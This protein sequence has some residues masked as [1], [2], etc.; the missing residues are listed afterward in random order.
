MAKDIDLSAF[1]EDIDLSAFDEEEGPS[2]LE[3][4]GRGAVQ[5][6][7]LGFGE[8]I[9]AAA[10]SPVEML[11]QKIAKL[12]PGSMENVDEQLRQQGFKGL[13]EEELTDI[14]KNLRDT[15]RERNKAAEEAHKATYIASDVAGGILPGL[16]SGGG[17]AAA[18][19]L[20]TGTKEAMKQAAK[21]GA[22]Y[23]AV[24]GLGYG[25]GETI[26]ED[27]QSTLVGGVLGAGLGA[28][29]PLAVKGAKIGA[30]KLKK[31]AQD[32]LET[33][34]P[35]S[36]A[37]KAGYKYGRQGK[38]LTQEVIDEDLI[39]I[40]KKIL[41]NIQSDKSAN[42]LKAAKE[43]L[44]ALG[45]VVNT[46]KTIN[47]AIDD[48]QKLTNEDYLGIQNKE[49]LPKI[50]E[51]TGYST[52]AERMAEKAQ[53]Q[54][55]KKVIESQGKIDQA[56]IKG[57]KDLAKAQAKTGD[58]LETITDVKRPMSDLDIPLQTKEG[59]VAGT[60]GRFKGPEGEDYIK[61][62][63]SDA[64][65]YQPEMTSM[66]DDLGRPIIKT[67]DKGS[68]RVS[69]MVG[70]IEDKIK[71]NLE[72]M[73]VSEVESLRKQLNLATKLAKA[74]GAAD[75]PIMQRA[76]KLAGELK[77][78][79]DEVVE[80]SGDTD[81]IRNRARFSDIFSAEEMLGIDKRFSVRRDIQEEL[82]ATQLGGKLGFEQGFKTRQEGEL[83][84]KLLG[85]KVVT[86]EMRQQL[87]LIRKLNQVSGRE[88]QE[89]ISRAGL[90][91]MVVG[92]IPNI[93]GRGVKA[94]GDI[95]RPITSPVKNTMDLLNT[96]T[97]QQVETFGAKLASSNKKGSQMLGQ[98]L[99]DAASQGGQA[100]SQAIWAISQSP[101]FRE[102]VKREVPNMEA[103]ME[104]TLNAL[105]PSA[106]A[107]DTPYS[108]DNSN[109]LDEISDS[110]GT[111]ERHAKR[112]GYASGYDVTLG[113]GKFDPSSD[114]AITEMTL[115]E[116]KD[117]QKKMLKHPKNN[118]NS[119]AIGRY[120]IVGKTLR[121]LQK[122]LGLSDD[123]VFDKATQDKMAEELLRQRGFGKAGIS[124][125]D[126][127]HNLSKEWA[128]IGD[129]KKGGESHYGGQ[130]SKAKDWNSILEEKESSIDL[131]SILQGYAGQT[132]DDLQ[133]EVPT[134]VPTEVTTEDIE[135]VNRHIDRVNQQQSSGDNTPVD[136]IE[137]LMGKIDALRLSEEDKNEIESEAVNMSGYSDGA[138]LKELLAKIA[139]LR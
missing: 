102:L 100:Q 36:E 137:G 120:Q 41:K 65:P 121:G 125:E 69:A 59:M 96:M 78:V 71:L 5:G 63:V 1:D 107:A 73:S 138:R 91:K 80:K 84:T 76:Q 22:G 127:Q 25:E 106:A 18:G 128:S 67:V 48:L 82:A 53:K 32:L 99:L 113:Y 117:F 47:D 8:E 14:Y 45:Y 77:K 116:V 39:G 72:N 15:T 17:T 115:S 55:T 90:Y 130:P 97:K 11:R 37:I 46:K 44:E 34:I 68:G 26:G 57:E 52:Q 103:E 58:V 35:E 31:G 49:L 2:Q 33:I 119:S 13:E 89:N 66:V 98:Q 24:S 21:V 30:G 12:I 28:A 6:V 104:S 85:E 27:I 3:A 51:L 136:Q 75:D 10:L 93:A 101:A 88:S 64:T 111:S 9:G 79:T 43:K 54:A 123:T 105:I 56:I 133:A 131:N 114:K 129:P 83:A 38:K 132:P 118:L 29:L 110:E 86:P 60:K 92:D 95:T 87:D 16:L 94:V 50:K 81:L 135:D 126:L 19:V 122:K 108:P 139:N 42:N 4:A 40:S 62:S 23:G 20:K 7:A 134:E 70:N 61:T 112:K 74:Q 109:V 124:S